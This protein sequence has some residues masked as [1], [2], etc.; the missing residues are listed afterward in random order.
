MG[1]RTD[2]SPV[3]TGGIDI[4]QVPYSEKVYVLITGYFACGTHPDILDSGR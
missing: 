3:Q 1:S 4:C 2:T